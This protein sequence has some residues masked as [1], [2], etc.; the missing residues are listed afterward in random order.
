MLKPSGTILQN[1]FLT[2]SKQISWN[3]FKNR[4]YAT[5]CKNNLFREALVTDSETIFLGVAVLS[6]SILKMNLYSWLHCANHCSKHYR[7][8]W[9]RKLALKMVFGHKKSSP[10]MRPCT[11]PGHVPMPA[12]LL[13]T[14]TDHSHTRQP[15]ALPHF[16]RD[17]ALGQSR[18]SRPHC[19]RVHA[20]SSLPWSG[21]H[22]HALLQ[23]RAARR[24]IVC[25]G[26]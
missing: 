24:G 20:P 21:C 25:C 18:R 11:S 13:Y 9:L 1:W 12:H 8:S 19:R 3:G 5:D 26:Q 2:R 15:A 22:C 10:M 6:E 17:T 16:L 23:A 7:V 14:P 4:H